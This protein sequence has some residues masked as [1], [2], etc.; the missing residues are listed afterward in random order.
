MLKSADTEDLIP[1]DTA[2]VQEQCYFASIFGQIPAAYETDCW[3]YVKRKKCVK[4][5]NRAVKRV[6]RELHAIL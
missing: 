6:F 1:V 3:L 4:L 2:Y 5:P